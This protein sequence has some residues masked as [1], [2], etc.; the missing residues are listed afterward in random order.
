MNY[1]VAICMALCVVFSDAHALYVDSNLGWSPSYLNE[2]LFVTNTGVFESFAGAISVTRSISIINSGAIYSDFYINGGYDVFVQNSGMIDGDF[3]VAPNARLIQIVTGNDDLNF[4]DVSSGHT[5]WVNN[6]TDISLGA[7]LNI[8]GGAD[9]IVLENSVLNLSENASRRVSGSVAGIEVLGDVVILLDSIDSVDYATPLLRNVSGEGTVSFDVA[10]INPL[11]RLAS[12]I[13]DGN[14]YVVRERETEYRK[15]LGGSLGEFLDNLRVGYPA[16]GLLAAMDAVPDMDGLMSVMSKSVRLHPLRLMDASRRMQMLD[17]LGGVRFSDGTD[18][19]VGADVILF[20]SDV[21]YRSRMSGGVSVTDDLYFS[22]GGFA[23]L[24]DTSDDINEFSAHLFGGE[25][26]LHYDDGLVVGT[27]A[28][29]LTYGR[30]D[31]GPVFNGTDVDYNPMG[32]AGF[33]SG[34]I[35]VH[36]GNTFGIV[37]TPLVGVFADYAN[38]SDDTDSVLLANIG[39]SADFAEHGFDVLYDYGIRG[40]VLTDGALH[41]GAFMKITAPEDGVSGILDFAAIHDDDGMGYKISVTAH[42][43]F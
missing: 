11:Y 3:S 22:I 2:D 39:L 30:F 4:I 18:F 21:I 16:D 14:L 40:N 1:F 37:L 29:G 5:V 42:V 41:V 33:A 17:S 32:L 20:D 36:I 9:K 35:G 12:R 23:G 27:A 19:N 24:Q 6:A 13:D 34:N 8:S 7:V 38:V 43:M 26:A 31:V 28:V 15:V 25:L 10:E